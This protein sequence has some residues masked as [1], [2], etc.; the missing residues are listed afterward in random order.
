MLEGTWWLDG[1]YPLVCYDYFS[2][3][4]VNN[5]V[6][7][8]LIS[9]ADAWW[10]LYWKVPKQSEVYRWETEN[11]WHK[12]QIQPESMS[13]PFTPKT[14]CNFYHSFEI[15]KY[16]QVLWWL[17]E[18]RYLEGLVTRAKTVNFDQNLDWTI[19][20]SAIARPQSLISWQVCSRHFLLWGQVLIKQ[21]PIKQ[22][23]AR[24]AYICLFL[25]ILSQG[26]KNIESV[27]QGCQ[28]DI[29]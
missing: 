23:Q 21:A 14:S 1:F 2:T 27:G 6:L 19:I 29:V 20:C 8:K 10:L 17:C 28:Q 15:C 16:I 3:C 22:R 7:S 25:I 26:V 5:V 11:Q 18:W 12:F 24:L 9:F 13:D 4:G